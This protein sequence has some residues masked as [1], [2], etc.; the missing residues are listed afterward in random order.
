MS[1]TSHGAACGVVIGIVFVVFLQQI[2]Y[3]DLSNLVPSLVDLA[4]GAVVGGVLGAVI[5][6]LLGRAYLARHAA[7]AATQPK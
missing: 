5:G 1:A 7:D 6:R 2:S 3:L 4:V